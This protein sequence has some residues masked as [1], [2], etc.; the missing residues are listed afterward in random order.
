MGKEY[1]GAKL[2]YFSS[3]QRKYEIREVNNVLSSLSLDNMNVDFTTND[4][5]NK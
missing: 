3:L 2:E 5:I 4:N 1:I